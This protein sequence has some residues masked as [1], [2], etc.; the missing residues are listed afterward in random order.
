[1]RLMFTLLL[2]VSLSAVIS[3]AAV[4]EASASSKGEVCDPPDDLRHV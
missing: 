1:M 4:M 2:A 3:R